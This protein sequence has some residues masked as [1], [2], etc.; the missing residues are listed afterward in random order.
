[1][2]TF[3]R[4]HEIE[5]AIHHIGDAQ[6][7]EPLLRVINLIHDQIEGADNETEVAE[8]IKWAVSEGQSGVWESAGNWSKKL[9]GENEGYAQAWLQL[10]K[11]QHLK[12]RFRVASFVGE[13][14]GLIG[15]EVFELL[16]NDASSKVREHAVG[17]NNLA[18]GLYR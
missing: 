4:E 16:S 8:A 6:R 15:E 12:V 13:I 9:C 14:P 3:G 2:F 18:N 7:A 1:M 11:H 17:K 5:Q 10:A